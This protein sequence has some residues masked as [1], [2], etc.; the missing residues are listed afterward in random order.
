MKKGVIA[1]LILLVAFVIFLNG[2]ETAKGAAQGACD[3]AKKDW[4]NAQQIDSKVREVLW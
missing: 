2:C 1:I 3:G 4:K